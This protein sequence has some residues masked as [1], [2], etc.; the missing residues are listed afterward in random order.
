MPSYGDLAP[1]VST[2]IRR[3]CAALL[4]HGGEGAIVKSGAVL[5]SGVI[6][7]ERY[8]CDA[9]SSVTWLRAA[10]RG[11]VEPAGPLRLRITTA[12]R[13]VAAEAPSRRRG[14]PSGAA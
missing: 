9:F 6:L 8:G 14:Q 5:A 1:I 12:G 2:T 13:A 3:A 10:T 4:A 11:L 7:G